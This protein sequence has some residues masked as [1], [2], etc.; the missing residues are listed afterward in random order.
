[1]FETKSE[2]LFHK[3]MTGLGW[4]LRKIPTSTKPGER[5]PDFEL[6]KD[7]FFVVAEVK[8]FEETEPETSDG[9]RVRS[10]ELGVQLR[11]KIHDHAE[12]LKP[13]MDR[14]PT[15]LVFYDGGSAPTTHGDVGVAMYGQWKVH[16][17]R[18]PPHLR[19]PDFAGGK[20][21]TTKSEKR[22]LSAVCVMTNVYLY[23]Y[24]NYFALHPLPIEALLDNGC[25]HF[26]KD[27]P[28][29]SPGYWTR[30]MSR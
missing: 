16:S 7:S 29:S 9:I 6:T 13:Y 1:M 4:S 18:N 30:A 25:Y 17:V 19:G 21:T 20:R 26:V 10:W 14:G 15:V 23:F 22:Y 2:E 3:W 24:H 8:E 12:Q 28:N 11:Q 27:D 5:T